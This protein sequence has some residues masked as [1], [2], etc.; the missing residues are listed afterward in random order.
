M[1]E[2]LPGMGQSLR[3]HHDSAQHPGNLTHPLV[4]IEGLNL[5]SRQLPHH[6]LDHFQVLMTLCGDLRQVGDG[7]DLNRSAQLSELLPNHLGDT[8]PDSTVHLIKD[9]GRNT[10][11][12]RQ[13]HLKGEADP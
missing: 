3:R 5:G 1:V 4:T 9:E 2:H 12:P 7:Q 10:F 6:A 13:R 8:A 11:P